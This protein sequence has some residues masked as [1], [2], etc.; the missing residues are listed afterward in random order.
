MKVFQTSDQ[1]MI[2]ENPGCLWLFGSFFAVIG[3]LF[4]YGAV[5][6]FILFGIHTP[7]AVGLT[8][9]LGILG[10]AIGF[11]VIYTTPISHLI[12]NQ[13]NNEVTIVRLGIFGR[14]TTVY[15]F[16]EIERFC[17]IE[18]KTG[19]GAQVWDFGLEL[20]DGE[21]IVVTSLGIHAEDYESKYVEPINVFTGKQTPLCQLNFEPANESDEE[22]S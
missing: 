9:L 17:L 1:L 15:H 10:I 14:R 20:V 21:Q 2:K 16:E 12:I 3:V 11:W 13:A 8:F 5:N 6:R 18:N 19:N 7:W 22:I 4:I